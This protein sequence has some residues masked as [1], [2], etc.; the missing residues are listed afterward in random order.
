MHY[1]LRHS[2]IWDPVHSKY[3]TCQQSCTDQTNA[4]Q[5]TMSDYP[6]K[7][8]FTHSTEF[9]MLLVKFVDQCKD[10]YKRTSLDDEGYPS[11]CPTIEKVKL[12]MKDKVQ[13]QVFRLHQF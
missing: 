11:I 4:V 5:T 12:P 7:P 1:V 2:Q 3:V 13:R 9:C 6:A 8:T 10:E